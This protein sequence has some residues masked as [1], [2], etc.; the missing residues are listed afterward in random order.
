MRHAPRPVRVTVHRRLPAPRRF[1]KVSSVPHLHQPVVPARRQPRTRRARVVVHGS[2]LQ[3]VRVRDGMRRRVIQPR[4]RVVH[5]DV[6]AAAGDREHVGRVGMKGRTAGRGDERAG[7]EAPR[8]LGFG[9]GPPSASTRTMA[10]KE[11]ATT[12][13]T[14]GSAADHRTHRGPSD[15]SASSERSDDGMV[16]TRARSP[17]VGSPRGS[18]EGGRR[19]MATP[20]RDVPS[21]AVARTSRTPPEPPSEHRASMDQISPSGCVNTAAQ[22][23]TSR[24]RSWL[25]M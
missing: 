9:S 2:N 14:A 15:A 4:A 8:V 6:R 7:G 12:A 5:V 16:P 20:P 18:R 3:R 23:A 24:S 11:S 13:S 25:T 17:R 10:R 19:Q 1:R 22:L 21:N